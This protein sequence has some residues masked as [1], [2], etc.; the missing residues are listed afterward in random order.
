MKILSMKFPEE[1]DGRLTDRANRR[2]MSKSA[3]VREMVRE[4]LARDGPA[5]PATFG[6]ATADLCGCVTDGPRDLA[7]NRA[8]LKGYGR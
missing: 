3:L 6:E 4:G 2:G 5:G 8:H 1:L 7:T